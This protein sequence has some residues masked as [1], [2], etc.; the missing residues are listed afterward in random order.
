MTKNK[1]GIKAWPGGQTDPGESRSCH[2]QVVAPNSSSHQHSFNEQ[3]SCISSK[4]YGPLPPDLLTAHS[5][6]HISN[7]T[8][9]GFF[10][11]CLA[12]PLNP[13][14]SILHPEARRG[15]EKYR[16]FVGHLYIFFG[17][18]SVS[19]F[20]PFFHWVAGFF[21]VEL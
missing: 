18:M 9:N 11:L 13:L 6:A 8:L 17:E 19:V 4:R 2:S 14:K 10:H 7:V 5:L 12:S 16:L 15:F 21:A 3:R 1:Q 20:C